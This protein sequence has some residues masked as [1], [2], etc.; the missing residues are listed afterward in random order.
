MAPDVTK[1]EGDLRT[2]QDANRETT[3]KTERR[4]PREL[5][6]EADP[7]YEWKHPP[8]EHDPARDPKNLPMEG[9]WWNMPALPPAI[10][11]ERELL[12][13]GAVRCVG[14]AE[15]LA[16]RAAGF[17]AAGRFADCA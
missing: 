6:M 11:A 10:R 12:A 5:P 16:D 7:N 9:G 14:Y 3:P 8:A 13:E 1:L 2:P 15:Q 4:A 17:G